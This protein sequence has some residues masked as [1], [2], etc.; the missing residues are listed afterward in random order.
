VLVQVFSTTITS[1]LHVSKQ[2]THYV[3][4]HQD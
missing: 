3:P 1:S 4:D 2:M